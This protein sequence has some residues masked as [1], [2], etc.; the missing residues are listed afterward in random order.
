MGGR[1]ISPRLSGNLK[2]TDVAVELPSE[3]NDDSRAPQI[4]RWDSIEA[5]G[6]YDAER[7]AS[8]TGGSL[9]DKSK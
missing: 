9:T 2:A 4:V 5:T 6:N 1:L 8:S 7:I 3:P